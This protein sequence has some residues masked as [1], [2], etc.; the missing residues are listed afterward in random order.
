MEVFV[1]EPSLE[2]ITYSGRFEALHGCSKVSQA[3]KKLEGVNPVEPFIQDLQVNCNLRENKDSYISLVKG[4]VKED[5]RARKGHVVSIE[6]QI[7]CLLDL[8][9]DRN[10]LGRM[11]EGYCPWI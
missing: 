8:A 4:D 7:D 5:I 10:V 1:K 2:W 6:E 9:T 11:Y 3:R